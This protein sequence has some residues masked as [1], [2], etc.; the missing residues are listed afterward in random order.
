MLDLAFLLSE[1][2]A[3]VLGPAPAWFVSRAANG[4]AAQMNDLEFSFLECAN[5][6][7]RLEAFQNYIVHDA[8]LGI[9]GLVVARLQDDTAH[10]QGCLC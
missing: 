2:F 5:F 10:R 8:L 7:R 6:V 3:N 1:G 4:H 9:D